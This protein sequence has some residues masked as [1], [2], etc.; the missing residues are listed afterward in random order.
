MIMILSTMMDRSYIVQ[1][2]ERPQLLMQDKKITHLITGIYDGNNSWCQPVALESPMVPGLEFM[3]DFNKHLSIL[4]FINFKYLKIF[5][6]MNYR[7]KT[8]TTVIF[9]SLSLFLFSNCDNQ[10]RKER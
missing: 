2:G 3:L 10:K 7:Y 5:F 4:G 9:L 8:F 6:S 1:G